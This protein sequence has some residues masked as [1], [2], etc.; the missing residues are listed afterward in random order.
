MYRCITVLTINKGIV[1]FTGAPPKS[2]T[3]IPKENVAQSP[4]SSEL[5]PF[6]LMASNVT[7][8]KIFACTN[9]MKAITPKR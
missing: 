6:I 1:T 5:T 3:R 8:T 2:A 4:N 9:N 7:G